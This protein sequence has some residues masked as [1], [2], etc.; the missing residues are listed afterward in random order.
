M[1]RNTPYVP[2]ALEAKRYY[3]RLPSKP[4][5]IARSSCDVWTKPTGL[6]AYFRPKSLTPLGPHLLN[7]VWEDNVGP[8]MAQYMLQ[9]GVQ[10]TTMTPLR[11]GIADEPSPPAV[12]LIGV[13]PGTLTHERGID[14]A[15]HCRSILVELG[16]SDVHVEIRES[17][18][19]FDATLYKPKGFSNPQVARLVEPFSTSLGLPIC[20]ATTT[21]HEG[22]SGFFFTDSKKPGKLF[23]LTTRH[24]LFHPDKSANKHYAFEERTG[25]PQ[26]KVMLL[27]QAA[28]NARV[29]QIQY[30][31]N[32]MK[33]TLELRE[34]PPV[35][36]LAVGDPAAYEEYVEAEKEKLR[37]AIEASEM[38]LAD[39][40][41]DWLDEENRVIG[42][43]VLSPPISFNVGNDGATEDWAVV[44][45]H[46]TKVS[47]LNFICNMIDLRSVD[48]FVL[49]QWM[50]PDPANPLFS[51]YLLN[52]VLCFSG[53]V[54]DQE[55]LKPSSLTKD[56]DDDPGIMVLKN[57]NTTGL[58]V[59]RLNT[60]RSFVRRDWKGQSSEQSKE[61]AVLPRAEL[62]RS[63]EPGV[64]SEPGDS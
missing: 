41:R 3:Y 43:V 20:N 48:S 18:A 21:H 58:T 22:T 63:S 4:R 46:A 12:V 53:V 8:A 31:I 39:V 54:S 5:L 35:V 36:Q 44:E 27:G 60:I 24:V 49:T 6:E 62:P 51:K 42:H 29:K 2:S 30:Q 45:M 7:D 61:I 1:S 10:W 23:M 17:E 38:L 56:Q 50:S 11:I 47:K 15:V 55:M 28:F 52:G 64:F 59:G 13:N 26:V 32:H 25:A 57:G 40:R 9:Q 19:H 16:I 34:K 37:S 14:V 33:N